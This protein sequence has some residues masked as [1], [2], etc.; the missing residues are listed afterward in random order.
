MR[1]MVP[2]F[3]AGWPTHTMPCCM[4]K[5]MKYWMVESLSPLGLAE[6]VK[7]PATLSFQALVNQRLEEASANFLNCHEAIPHVSGRA[8]DDGVGGVQRSPI[9]VGD[10]AV[11]I[12]GDGLGVRALRHELGHALGVAVAGMENNNSFSHEKCSLERLKKGLSEVRWGMDSRMRG[13]DREVR[14]ND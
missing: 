12:D 8:K 6:M 9:G 11:G 1:L 4:A 5:V 14:G 10:V 3:M 13:N 7:P 2:S